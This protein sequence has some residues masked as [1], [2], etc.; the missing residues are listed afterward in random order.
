VI[1]VGQAAGLPRDPIAWQASG[2]PHEAK[3][4]LMKANT[5]ASYPRGLFLALVTVAVLAS[6]S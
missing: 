6:S 3:D 4:E 2:L 5:I 1:L